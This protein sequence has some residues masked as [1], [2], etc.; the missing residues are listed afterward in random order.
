[1]ICLDHH[2]IAED[3]GKI[4]ALPKIYLYHFDSD[5]DSQNIVMLLIAYLLRS[6]DQCDH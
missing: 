4:S 2:I 5:T 3:G 6:L 1:M